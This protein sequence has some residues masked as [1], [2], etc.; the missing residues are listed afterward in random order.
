MRFGHDIIL[1]RVRITVKVLQY[2][3][4][5]YDYRCKSNKIFNFKL[6]LV[7][8]LRR[9]KSLI[10][11][12]NVARVGLKALSLLRN[13]VLITNLIRGWLR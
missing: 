3:I 9:V 7:A 10:L 12:D 2:D 11:L 8:P 6:I 5:C 4:W 1:I 13:A